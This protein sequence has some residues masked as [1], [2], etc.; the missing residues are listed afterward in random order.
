MCRLVLSAALIAVPC[1]ALITTSG[2]VNTAVTQAN[3]SVKQDL[4]LER[5]IVRDDRRPAAAELAIRN[6]RVWVLLIMGIAT[7]GLLT[8]PTLLGLGLQLGDLGIQIRASNLD[9]WLV[10]SAFVPHS[11]L[12]LTSYILAGAAG[13]GGPSLLSSLARKPLTQSKRQ[14]MS[15]LS[16]TAVSLVLLVLAAVVEIYVTPHLIKLARP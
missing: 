16:W 10:A 15:L 8:V 2:S 1:L 14:L 11:A 12:E 4:R 7:G 9:L 13:L 3:R 5:T 6:G